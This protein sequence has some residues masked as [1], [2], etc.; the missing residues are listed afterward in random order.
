MQKPQVKLVGQ[1]GNAF[2]FIGLCHRAAKKAKWPEAQWAA[3]SK[4]MRAGDYDHLLR[5]A[6]QYFDVS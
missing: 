5:V 1:D 3:V 2:A 6:M 4:E